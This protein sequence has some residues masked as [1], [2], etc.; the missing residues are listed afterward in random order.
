V[1]TVYTRSTGKVKHVKN[2]GWLLR[3]A[4]E[5]RR[6]VVGASL[7]PKEGEVHMTAYLNGDVWYECFWASASVCRDWLKRPSLRDVPLSWFGVQ[8]VTSP[9][10]PEGRRPADAYA[11]PAGQLQLDVEPA[12][13]RKPAV[14][15]TYVPRVRCQLVREA[16]ATV[17]A[18][19]CQCPANA[20]AVASG[21]I[22]AED[23]EHL[24]CLLLDAR[25]KLTAVSTVSI[26]DLNSSLVHPREVLKA[27]ILHNAASII[28]AHNHPSGDP[29]P[30]A[31]DI[32]VTQRL[33]QAC[34]LLGV[35]LIDHIIV[36]EN[37]RYASLAERGLMK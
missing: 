33:R 20:A 25:N 8:S 11:L 2:L 30:S 29:T 22:G 28:L 1:A 7:Y 12:A 24:L 14:T 16:G 5:V 18:A 36:G 19:Y 6:I 21:L 32:A 15:P 26:G 31:D 27:A 23:R 17:P 4:G 9:L 3:H 34:R 13:E 10:P 37:G 35:E